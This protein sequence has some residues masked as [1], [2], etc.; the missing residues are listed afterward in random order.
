VS[1]ETGVEIVMHPMAGDY[2]GDAFAIRYQ[3]GGA[4]QKVVVIDSG[5]FELDARSVKETVNT[6]F[7][8]K[9]T[10][11]LI[12]THSDDD[13]AGG[14]RELIGLVDDDFNILEVWVNS[15]ENT[16]PLSLAASADTVKKLVEILNEKSIVFCPAVAGKSSED[17]CII[18]LGPSPELFAKYR[19]RIGLENKTEEP[20]GHVAT[21]STTNEANRV[22]VISVLN[23]GSFQ[24]LFTGDAGTESIEDAARLLGEHHDPLKAVLIQVPHPW[25][26]KQLQF[27]FG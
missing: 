16:D 9:V 22:S 20:P 21:N 13:H 25:K 7:R 26:Y 5:R 12:V 24:A 18:L 17:G 3:I 14:A 15:S 27:C 6:R 11:L 10:D 19:G 23:V 1:N 8:S 4:P 2:D